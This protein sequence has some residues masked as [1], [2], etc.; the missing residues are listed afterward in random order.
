LKANA[1]DAVSAHF[2]AEERLAVIRLHRVK[3]IVIAA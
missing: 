2:D 3:A 1:T